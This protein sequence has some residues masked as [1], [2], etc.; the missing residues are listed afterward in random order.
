VGLAVGL[1]TLLRSI[2]ILFM[3]DIGLF[4]LADCIDSVLMRAAGTLGMDHARGLI[5][6]IR[7]KDC[8]TVYCM[9]LKN[10]WMFTP[11]KQNGTMLARG[12]LF[13]TCRSA[14]MQAKRF[15]LEDVVPAEETIRP[16]IRI[17]GTYTFDD[18]LGERALLDVLLLILCALEVACWSL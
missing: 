18:I 8:G 15:A 16:K 13:N 2:C 5:I 17:L 6:S 12:K 9:L 14:L 7:T 4:S 1:R 11:T 10:S 3:D